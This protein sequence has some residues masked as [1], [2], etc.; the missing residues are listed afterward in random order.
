M[1]WYSLLA[2][3][4]VLFVLSVALPVPRRIWAFTL[5][6]AKY[7]WLWLFDVLRPAQAVARDHRPRRE[8]PAS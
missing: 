2:A 5:Y 6:T 3:V 4:A 7:F 8:V 1:F